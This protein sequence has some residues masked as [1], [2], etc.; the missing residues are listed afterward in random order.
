MIASA[1]RQSLQRRD[2][3]IHNR[4]SVEVNFGRFLADLCSTPIWWRRAKFSSSRAARERKVEDTVARSVVRAMS[5][6][7]NYEGNITPIRSDTSRFSRGTSYDCN[8][9]FEV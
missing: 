1:E 4:R 7:K 5:I 6:G 2:R 9:I 3:Q 8:F